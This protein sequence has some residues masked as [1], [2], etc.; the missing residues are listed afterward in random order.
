MSALEEDLKSL[1]VEMKKIV[2]IDDEPITRKLIQSSLK[3]DFEVYLVGNVTEALRICE[4]QMPDM[5]LLDL[6][7]PNVD[8]FEMLQLLKNNPSL[9]DIPVL[10]MSATDSADNR[11]RVHAGGASGFIKKPID[12]RTLPRDVKHILESMNNN[13]VSKNKRVN[14]SVCFNEVEKDKRIL[15][16]IEEALVNKEKVIYLS[17]EHGEDY[18][19]SNLIL[20]KYIDNNELIYLEIKPNLISKF[21]YMQDLSSL[22]LDIEKFIG[23]KSR[24]YHLVLDEPRQLLNVSH[25]D[26]TISQAYSIGMLFH[27]SF[28]KVS[29]INTRPQID[30]DQL[31]LNKIGKILIG[32]KA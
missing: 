30:S 14:F 25:K 7:M 24:D 28:M 2:V 8:G 23:G 10:C 1:K 12:R 6:I 29:Y 21:P 31:F 15:K 3:N 11:E 18:I 20:K 32:V 13:I 5:I 27:G 4:L 22:L 9:C 16:T 19:S 26:K 17:W